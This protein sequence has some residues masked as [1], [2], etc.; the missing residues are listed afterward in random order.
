MNRFAM[1]VLLLAS[2][3]A[4]ALA[5][6]GS[7]MS[8]PPSVSSDA[9]AKTV[10]V[11]F[12]SGHT[13]NNNGLNYNGDAKGEKTLTVPLGWTIEMSLANEGKLPH[14][15][16]VLTGSSLPANIGGAKLAFPDAAS[17]VLAPGAGAETSKFVANRPGTYLIV[18]RVGRHA[19]NGMYVKMVVSN[20][21]KEASYK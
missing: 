5:Q 2:L 15:F 17:K 3:S 1:S 4:P 12:V 21:V 20:S 8:M 13:M 19:A 14:D 9:A 10:K 7:T 18:C 16:A 11:A 6:S